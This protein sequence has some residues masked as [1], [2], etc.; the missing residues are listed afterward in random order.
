M[1]ILRLF[2]FT[3]SYTIWI[4]LYVSGLGKNGS[5]A[6]R[7]H[8][9]RTAFKGC[10]DGVWCMFHRY[11]LPVTWIETKELGVVLCET[12][13]HDDRSNGC[14]KCVMVLLA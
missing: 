4:V 2:I 3:V 10:A 11:V 6:L 1:F 14:L 13:W 9:E 7:R 8:S 12:T 5:L